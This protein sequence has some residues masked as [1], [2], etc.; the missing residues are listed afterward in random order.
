MV[1]F[2]IYGLHH[3][4]LWGY[5]GPILFYI[6]QTITIGRL[7][8]G[9]QGQSSGSIRVSTNS[10]LYRAIRVCYNLQISFLSF[11]CVTFLGYLLRIHFAVIHGM[12]PS[13]PL[14]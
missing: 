14:S 2:R 7:S 9:V 1:L 5:C 4:Y 3:V 11:I 10:G 12:G 13:C 8:I 6:R